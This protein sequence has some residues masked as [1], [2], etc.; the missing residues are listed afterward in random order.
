MIMLLFY[1]AGIRFGLYR[2]KK[3][4]I[5]GGEEIG[6]QGSAL[7]GLMGLFLAF[8]FGAAANRYDKRNEIIIKE[9]NDI[10]TA[11]LRADLYDDS[12][13]NEFRKDFKNYVEARIEFFEAGADLNKIYAALDKTQKISMLLWKRATTLSKSTKEN[14]VRYIQMIPALNSMIDIVSER[15][16]ASKIKV[17]EFILWILF[18]LCFIVSFIMGYS[19]RGKSDWVASVGFSL[20]ISLTV[21]LILDLDRPRRG[22]ITAS[23][24]QQQIIELREMFKE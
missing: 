20:V 8:T 2:A 7:M 14:A 19:L 24:A 22:I 10:G 5:K 16:A 15:N 21:F 23:K 17:P 13:R 9:A 3:G 11:I 6:I 12:V 1:Y 4:R 18:S